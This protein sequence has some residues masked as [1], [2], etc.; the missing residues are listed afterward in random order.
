MSAYYH[1]FNINIISFLDITEII[2]LQT[3][4]FLPA[5][6][7]IIFAYVLVAARFRKRFGKYSTV[8]T[9]TDDMID[10]M[11]LSKEEKSM[12]KGIAKHYKGD[13]AD[14]YLMLSMSALL[15][16][17]MIGVVISLKNSYDIKHGKAIN[18]VTMTI[19]GR[20][21]K[22]DA[23]NMFIG[24]AKNFIFFYNIRTK[25]SKI[26]SNSDVKDL[27]YAQGNEYIRVTQKFIDSMQTAMP[28]R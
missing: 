3:E 25:E 24:R 15:I 7:A 1:T 16:G 27:T 20:L 12:Y 19:D 14:V 21:V 17:G 4:F 13:I 8:L 22:T 9:P 10:N 2:Q 26:Y 6:I 11:D 23:N 28:P 18:E 5:I